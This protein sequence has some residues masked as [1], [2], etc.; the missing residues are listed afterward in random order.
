M[1]VLSIDIGI[2]HLGLSVS[3]INEDYTLN[4]ITHIDMIDITSFVHKKI[5]FSECTLYH[6]RT[7]SDWILHV[8]QENKEYFDTADVILIER[9][10]PGT[11]V[12]IEQFIFS[13]F[14]DKAI[15]LSPRVLHCH[16]KI[17]HLSYDDRK[18]F[19]VDKALS[20][21]SDEL[22]IKLSLFERAHDIADS[23]CFTLYWICVKKNEYDKQQK[24][25]RIE[26]NIGNDGLNPFERIEQYRYKGRNKK[27]DNPDN[28]LVYNYLLS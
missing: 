19:I 17:Q 3:D 26:Q 12:A 7:I 21:L 28:L 14:R 22:K 20:E 4:K 16:F 5:S 24:I 1:K 27:T 10:P 2:L 11:F 23:I 13:I 9:Q 25:L 18:K 15:L 8:I 6:T